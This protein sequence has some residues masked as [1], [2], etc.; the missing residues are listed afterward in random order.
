MKT[1]M[2]LPLEGVLQEYRV[3]KGE[4]LVRKPKTLTSVESCTLPIAGVTAWMAL[5]GMR[6]CK[7]CSFLQRFA[8]LGI[9]EEVA[10]FLFETACRE[11]SYYRR[12]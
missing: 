9:L 12:A 2:G 1:G 4:S 3:L 5:N 11:T 6:P 10:V 7:F 8:N